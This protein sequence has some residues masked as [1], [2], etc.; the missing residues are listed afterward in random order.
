MTVK[1]A[2]SLVLF[3]PHVV[4]TLIGL[5]V[6]DLGNKTDTEFQCVPL[7]FQRKSVSFEVAIFSVTDI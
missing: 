2:D 5:H 4:H 3:S 7:I 6:S 1:K